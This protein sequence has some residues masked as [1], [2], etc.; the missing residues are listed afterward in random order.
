METFHPT[1]RAFYSASCLVIAACLSACAAATDT[2]VHT[3]TPVNPANECESFLDSDDGLVC[4]TVDSVTRCVFPQLTTPQQTECGECAY[5][6]NCL[7]PL[8]VAPDTTGEACEFDTGCGAYHVCI[9]GYCTMDPRR[10]AC[11]RDEQCFTGLAC[12]N[13]GFC[14]VPHCDSA[15]DCNDM[16]QCVDGACVPPSNGMCSIVA[17][18]FA[19]AWNTESQLNMREVLPPAIATILDAVSGPFAYISGETTTLETG[20][21]EWVNDAIESNLRDWSDE[22]LDDW[23]RDIM[24]AISQLNGIISTWKTQEVLT[25]THADDGDPTHYTGTQQWLAVEFVYNGVT[26]HASA[27]DIEGWSFSPRDFTARAEC[28]DLVIDEHDVRVSVG[29][30]I[31]WLVNHLVGL[32]THGRYMT[33]GAALTNLG[34]DICPR[35]ANIAQDAVDLISHYEV[36]DTILN[37]CTSHWP[38]WMNKVDDA[39]ADARVSANAIQLSGRGTIAGP[40]TVGPGTW[41]GGIAGRPFS[42]TFHSYR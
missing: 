25:F 29:A 18:N 35:V 9:S 37:W 4:R 7:G 39:I 21:P 12:N 20:F 11:T 31:G 33:L 17:P 42:G 36:H 15:L 26:L 6:A 22:H 28:F 3:P 38:Q 14:G 1:T 5:P 2:G 16:F 23:A 8:C 41:T 40:N 27:D 30:V 34:G 24:R 13:D 10:M 19:G 32:V